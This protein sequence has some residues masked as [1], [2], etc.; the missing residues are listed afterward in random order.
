VFAFEPDA[1]ERRNRRPPRCINHKYARYIRR[2][3][4]IAEE[5][6]LLAPWVD[7]IQ[8]YVGIDDEYFGKQWDV[9]AVPGE[10]VPLRPVGLE[11]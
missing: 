9:A 3:K 1:P 6:V 8:M 2:L 10:T 5:L 11:Q 7:R 4:A